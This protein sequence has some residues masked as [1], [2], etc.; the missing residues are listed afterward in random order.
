MS[1]VTLALAKEHLRVDG[2]D[3]DE[4]IQLYL[5]AAEIAAERYLGR[6]I[7]ATPEDVPDDDADGMALNASI[8]AAVLVHA[9]TLYR[10]RESIGTTTGTVVPLNSTT[11]A[12]LDSYRVSLGI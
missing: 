3:E 10:W 4:L 12:L 8:V 5:D 11:R 9:A 2:T 7:Y 6:T 1:I